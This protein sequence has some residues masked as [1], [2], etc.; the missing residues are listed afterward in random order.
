[1]NLNEQRVNFREKIM[2]EYCRDSIESVAHEHK[3]TTLSAA[4]VSDNREYYRECTAFVHNAFHIDLAIVGID[5]VF[6][7]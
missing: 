2:E 7:N 3:K 6:Y 1:M 4:D 5:D